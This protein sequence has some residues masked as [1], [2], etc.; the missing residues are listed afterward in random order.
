[1]SQKA[2]PPLRHRTSEHTP[3]RNHRPSDSD[4]T[5]ETHVWN[6]EPPLYLDWWNTIYI[7]ICLGWCWKP[8]WTIRIV[9]QKNWTASFYNSLARSVNFI[10]ENL[11]QCWWCMCLAHDEVL[12][13]YNRLDV[14]PAKHMFKTN[15]ICNS[16]KKKLNRYHFWVTQKNKIMGII[17]KYRLSIRPYQIQ[18]ELITKMMWRGFRDAPCVRKILR[19]VYE[20]REHEV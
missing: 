6:Y 7:C 11:V 20:Q 17:K 10:I 4:T 13:K 5:H 1:M 2:T 16:S 3:R 18:W 14:E 8:L 9:T 15:K 19:F 12:P